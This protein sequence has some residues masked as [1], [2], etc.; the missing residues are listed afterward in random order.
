MLIMLYVGLNDIDLCLWF[1]FII[2]LNWELMN[3]SIHM[4]MNLEYNLLWQV[5]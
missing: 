4:Y 1:Y 2:M 3:K 5:E